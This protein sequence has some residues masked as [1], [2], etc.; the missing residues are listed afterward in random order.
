MSKYDPDTLSERL[1]ASAWDRIGDVSGLRDKQG[2]PLSRVVAI[3][4][5]WYYGNDLRDTTYVGS[6]HN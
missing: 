3:Q 4:R 2:F 5:V 6:H 1:V